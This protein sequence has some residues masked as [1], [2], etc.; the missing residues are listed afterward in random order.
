[1]MPVERIKQPPDL[2][3]VPDIAPLK[4]GQSHLAGIDV[5]QNVGDFHTS[6]F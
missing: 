4:L 2:I 1:M 3:A 5:V 6:A